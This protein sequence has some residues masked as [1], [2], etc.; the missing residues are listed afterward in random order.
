M[1]VLMVS[2]LN[3]KES[4]GG[5]NRAYYLGKY[6]SD[7]IDRTKPLEGYLC[8]SPGMLDACMA[9]MKKYEMSEDRIYF[10]KFA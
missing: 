10:D 4:Y 1:R 8:G 5:S 3:T 2:K 7:Q 9:V 6:L